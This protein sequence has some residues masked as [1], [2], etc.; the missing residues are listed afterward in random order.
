[1]PFHPLFVG[2]GTRLVLENVHNVARGNAR[3]FLAPAAARAMRASER[4]L[5]EYLEERVPVY[6]VTTHFGNQA[7]LIEPHL[8]SEARRY[9]ASIR[10]RQ[11][12]LVQ[13]HDCGVGE[14][15]PED[16]A[17]AAMLLRAQCLGQGYSGVRPAAV[18]QLA[19][20]LNKKIH[21]VIFRY[22]SIGASGDLIPLSAIAAALV[23]LPRPVVAGGARMRADAALRRANIRPLALEGREG[24]A[25]IN[26]TSFSTAIAALALRDLRELF[27]RLL[28]TIGM[29]LEALQVMDSAYDPIVH[30]VKGH[31]GQI[32]VNGWLAS[33]WKGSTL[34]R[35]L[36]ASRKGLLNHVS[37]G[38]TKEDSKI[39]QDYY[40]LRSV[41]QGFGP[42]HENLARAT[43]WIE[44][45]INSVND[46]P[47]T[48][49]ASGK[50]LHSANFMGYYVTSACDM[51]K[52]DIAQ[53]STWIHALLANFVHP[54]KNF[55]LPANL[56]EKPEL[57]NAFRPLQLLAASLAVQNRKNAQNQQAF[58]LPTE[59]DNQDV[60]SLSKHAAFDFR[61]SVANLERLTGILLLAAAQGLE[62]R[63][64]ARA[65]K[66]A[67]NAHAALR[68]RV[69][70]FAKD[71]MMRDD[72]EKAIEFLRSAA[73]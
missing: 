54:R 9:W 35:R 70:F 43:A 34:I 28:G 17:R 62:F 16:V 53:A 11:L 25:L 41:A 48:D 8:K 46:N 42:F 73:I 6:G 52:A 32:A 24:L 57:Y 10:A 21:P 4:A 38:E 26:G 27:E 29:S 68:K 71:R 66:R 67:R 2:R 69:P 72:L 5:H 15:L 19:A 30:R 20:L 37:S 51:L 39:L 33:F 63:G 14:E 60:N 40:S 49:P 55:G 59:G 1:M 18:E 45:E 56:I 65:G 12:N 61:E 36:E 47:V 44:T 3:V 58:M 50:I 64:V 23:G 31:T 7:H 22:G 13:S